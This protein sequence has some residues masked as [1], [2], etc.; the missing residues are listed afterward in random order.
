MDG[1]NEGNLQMDSRGHDRFS[2][3]L[4]KLRDD[5]LLGLVYNES[6]ED[7]GDPPQNDDQSK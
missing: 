1:L 4:T 5:R 3:R 6:G 7:E 2:H